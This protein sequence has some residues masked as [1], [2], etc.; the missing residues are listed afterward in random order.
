MKKKRSLIHNL[1]MV[2][3]TAMLLVAVTI[4][5]FVNW[6]SPSIETLNFSGTA[7][8]VDVTITSSDAA[9]KTESDG[10]AIFIAE[11]LKPGD[12]LIYHVKLNN[13][14]EDA[15]VFF[16]ISDVKNYKKASEPI[17]SGKEWLEAVNDDVKLSQAVRVSLWGKNEDNTYYE[18][19][20]QSEIIKDRE[21]FFFKHSIQLKENATQELQYRLE[22]IGNPYSSNKYAEKKMTGKFAV[23]STLAK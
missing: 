15:S 18:I 20:E 17:A 5:W 1:I 10:S 9:I 16:G 12:Q 19:P 13:R 11:N 2:L 4:A 3:T 23:T 22:F 7:L 21:S 14:G 6:A 8:S